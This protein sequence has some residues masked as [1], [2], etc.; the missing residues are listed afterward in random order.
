MLQGVENRGDSG[1]SASL[2]HSPIGSKYHMAKALVTVRY[3]NRSNTIDRDAVLLR[4][5]R[6]AG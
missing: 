2:W 6:V 4:S 3:A 5:N 1:I